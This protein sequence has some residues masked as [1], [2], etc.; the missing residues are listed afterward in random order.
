MYL[1]LYVST[2]FVIKS[3]K[4]RRR[5]SLFRPTLVQPSGRSTGG[6]LCRPSTRSM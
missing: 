3:R 1:Y 5:P 2:P 4:K 6:K